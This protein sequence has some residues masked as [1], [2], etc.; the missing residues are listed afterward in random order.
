MLTL[1]LALFALVQLSALAGAFLWAKPTDRLGPKRVVAAMLVQWSVVTVAAYFVQTK[2]QFFVLAVL[3]G[4]WLRRWDV[5]TASGVTRP[6]R[7]ALW[8]AVSVTPRWRAYARI[9]I[10]IPSPK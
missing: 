2:A 7:I 4:A 10:P 8:T 3:A 6:A 5:R 1:L 9:E